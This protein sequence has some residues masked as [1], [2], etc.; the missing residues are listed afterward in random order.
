MHRHS[1]QQAEAGVVAGAGAGARA[2]AGG[3]AEA[4]AC[5][6]EVAEVFAQ[7]STL[8]KRMDEADQLIAQLLAEIKQLRQ[9][10]QDNAEVSLSALS[11]AVSALR[12]RWTVLRWA[13]PTHV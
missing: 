12:L 5:K 6:A 10:S 9:K 2:G 11:R 4:G 7:V 1:V 3:G 13:A 8:R